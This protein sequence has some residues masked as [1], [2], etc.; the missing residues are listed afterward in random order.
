MN[1]DILNPLTH[2]LSNCETEAIHSPGLIQP[3]GVL[4]VL[5]ESDLQ[6]IRVSDNTEVFFAIEAKSLIGRKLDF[7]FSEKQIND[8]KKSLQNLDPKIVQSIELERNID[9]QSSLFKGQYHK[10][11]DFVILEL[12]KEDSPGLSELYFYNLIKQFIENIKKTENFGE[13]IKLV[14]QEIRSITGY[15]RVMVYQ[16][17][18]DGSGVVIAESKGENVLE[19]YLDMHYPAVDIPKQA[20]K[21]Y[22]QNWVR[23]ILDTNYEPVSLFPPINPVTEKP[24]DLSYSVLRS[25]SSMHLEYCHNMGLSGS[26]TISIVN[27]QELAG[28]IVCHHYSPRYINYQTR[29]YCEF[30]GKLISLEFFH[31]QEKEAE[32]ER[33]KI[34]ELKLKLGYKIDDKSVSFGNVIKHNSLTILDL[35][36]AQGAALYLGDELILIGATP[37]EKQ[38]RDLMDWFFSLPQ[39]EVFSTSS[40]P[41]IYP[42]AKKFKKEAAGLLVISI[43]LHNTSYHLFW[44]RTEVIQTVNWGGNPHQPYQIDPYNIHRL[45]PRGSFDLWRESVCEK[46]LSWQPVEIEAALE[47]RSTLLLAALEFSQ[48]AL[49]KAAEQ[50]EIANRTKSQFLARMSHELRTPLNAILGFAQ[51]MNRNTNLSI[52]QRE[53]IDIINRSGEHLLA[54][55]NDVL[56][57]SKIEA[58]QQTF[59][60]NDFNL[61]NLLDSLKQIFTMKAQNKGL[62]LVFDLR[63]EVPEY[64]TTDENK[65]RQVLSNLLDNAFKFTKV[66]QITVRVS[67]PK[68][69]TEIIFEVADT[70]AGIAEN[71]IG[72]LFEPFVQTES[73]RK[74]MQG[75][76]LGLPISRQFVRLLGGEMTVRSAV[77]KGSTF[78][79][80][81]K[82]ALCDRN[83][84][85]ALNCERRIIGLEPNQLNYR[86]LVVEDVE[87]NRRLL[88]E[89][90][91]TI[92]FEVRTAENGL[93]AL[94]IWQSWRPHLIWMDILMPIMD[95]YEATKRIKATP[96]GQQTVIIALTA[97]AFSSEQKTAKTAGCNDFLSKPY[98]EKVLLEKMAL[99]LGV[100]YY[101]ETDPLKSQKARELTKLTR[102]EL[103]VMPQLWLGKVY[104]AASHLDEETI[105]ELIKEI[106]DEYEVIARKLK[107]LVNNYRL[108]VILELTR[109]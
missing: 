68:E 88:W 49:Q 98:R 79:F 75:T 60:E 21:L 72:I 9:E 99:H 101:Y 66:G 64:I 65:L 82:V 4:F 89:L 25:V 8:F 107:E 14:A 2:D 30:L 28:L 100:R 43:F 108:D 69:K 40:L 83:D 39:Q 91:N 11:E 97:N 74:S 103:L 71:E 44:F 70:G 41:E 93:E 102:E 47:L 7:L 33:E 53:Y 76:G 85:I 50:A 54:L 84:V 10:N 17:E 48:V 95:G 26:M 20:R 106:P 78:T 6:I 29:Y 57:M 34:K 63:P 3:H 105:L 81:I 13:T 80:N 15:D 58:G 42:T 1:T 18:S 96:E 36:K 73:G 90:M 32:K 22:V 5:A 23:L 56:E 35:V 67:C 87:Q 51:L 62:E 31:Q 92:G 61:Y 12:E 27:K 16:F 86:I 59:N 38:V 45:S 104:Q 46:S 52:D 37:T 94:S 109:V 19:S 55:I 77:R 24:V